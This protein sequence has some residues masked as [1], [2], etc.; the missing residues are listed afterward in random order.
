MAREKFTALLQVEGK[1]ATFIE[2][3]LDIPAVFG[4]KRVPVRGTI[5]G[6]H[7]RSTIATYG[8]RFYLPVNKGVRQG[9]GA[10]AG[11]TV[12]VELERDEA[13]RMVDIP[14]DLAKALKAAP[15]AGK[16]FKGLS[17]THQKEYV[18]WITEAKRDATRRTRV[19]K[20]ISMLQ[21]GEKH[22]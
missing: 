9:A 5:N 2:V 21:A 1:T 14:A 22:P 13:R 3:P 19:E 4:G 10:S 16:S 15:S 6:F 20:T 18:A 11:E 7:F 8:D 12:T 17:Y